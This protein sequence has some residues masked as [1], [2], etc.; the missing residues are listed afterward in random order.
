MYVP[1]GPEN[2]NHIQRAGKRGI[3]IFSR[4]NSE[5]AVDVPV[6]QF[7]FS[8]HIVESCSHVLSIEMRQRYRGQ[9]SCGNE[10][11]SGI[12]FVH[13]SFILCKDIIIVDKA[14]A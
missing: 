3:Q 12:R 6:S 4:R 9:T 13:P 1:I 8:R 5:N 14:F 7:P 2:T 11:F 10:R